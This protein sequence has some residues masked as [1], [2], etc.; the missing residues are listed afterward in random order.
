MQFITFK[1]GQMVYGIPVE[2]VVNIDMNS[3]VTRIPCDNPNVVGIKKFHGQTIPVF[4]LSKK[5]GI[6]GVKS[7]NLIVVR[8]RDM[9]VG[10]LVEQVMDLGDSL[11]HEIH[12]MPQMIK[13]IQGYM[14]DV[15]HKD[16]ALTVVVDME[17]LLD[18]EDRNALKGMI[19]DN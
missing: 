12:D 5:F 8:C 17:R 11:S 2:Q 10:I 3:G 18:E 14:S 13:N 1:L 7:Q 19:K 6:P 15:A 16:G 9:I 4:D